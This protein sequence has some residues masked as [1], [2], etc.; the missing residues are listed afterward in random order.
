MKPRLARDII[1]EDTAYA[2][3]RM[4]ATAL[5]ILTVVGTA[6]TIGV[7]WTNA[8]Q[9]VFG[10]A[11]NPDLEFRIFFTSVLLAN[12]FIDYVIYELALSMFD[13]ADASL[14]NVKVGEGS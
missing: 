12:L 5:M 6:L 14:R 3:P 11:I 7:A 2:A 13:R 10:P 8:W 9:H 1:R 4:V